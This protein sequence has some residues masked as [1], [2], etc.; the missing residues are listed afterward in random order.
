M[1]FHFLNG[2]RALNIAAF[3]IDYD[4]PIFEVGMMKIGT[5]HLPY[6]KSFHFFILFIRIFLH[7]CCLG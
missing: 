3:D 1:V 6:V 2:F 5:L 7:Y 4:D